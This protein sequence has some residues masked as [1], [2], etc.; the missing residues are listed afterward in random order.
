MDRSEI[1]AMCL[2]IRSFCVTRHCRDCEI[3]RECFLIEKYGSVPDP[4]KW[5][6]YDM[7]KIESIITGEYEE[8]ENTIED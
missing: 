4:C 5:G 7:A 1:L 6:C 2:R 3:R 8:A